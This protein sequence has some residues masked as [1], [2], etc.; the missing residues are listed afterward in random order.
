MNMSSG[1][2]LVLRALPSVDQILKTD[3]AAL[4]V[5]Q[6]GRPAAVAAVRQTLDATRAALRAGETASSKPEVIGETA[7]ARLIADAQPKLGPVFNLTGTVLHTN[8][9][10]ALL[11]EAA[12][13]AAVV[14]MRSA[15]ALEFDLTSGKRGERDDHIRG[16]LCELSG[17]ADATIVNNNA[18]AVLLTLNTLA[19][20]REAVVSR[21][22]LIEIGGAFRMPDIMARAGAR[23]VEVGTTNRTHLKDYVD[24][25]GDK[26]G[27]V[28]KVHTSN[29]RIAGF[30]KE[31]TTRELAPV[32]RERGVP[33]V[34]DLG[35]GTMVDLSRWGLA[36]E[37]TVAEAVA[38]GADIVT[39]SGDKLMGASQLGF[40]VGRKDLIAKIN[41]NPMKRALRADKIRLAAV[42]ATLRLYRDPDRLAEQLPTIRMLARSKPAI[43]AMAHRLAPIVAAKVGD[44]FTVEVVDCASQIG[45][46]ALPLETLPSAALAIRPRKQR[47][48]GRALTRLS[49]ALR[50]L[51]VP[52]IG[53]TEDGA[54][55]LDLRCLEDEAAFTSNLT[56]LDIGD[57]RGDA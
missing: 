14:A 55:I 53:R 6:F 35:S 3:A 48:A 17:A 36:H 32:A 8:L 37:P 44:A 57:D 33:L 45:S 39:F 2:D 1:P 7:L 46:G 40:I 31:V 56:D 16:L 27:L 41:R 4:A 21:G 43:K 54:Q 23:L 9:G 38:E 10:R 22:E 34:N 42:A 52:A 51:P 47:G 11:A 13:E 50:Q 15:V 20:G 30:T 18:A 19:K 28:L 29:Y 26:T 25:I 5:T 12:V 49:A 24:A